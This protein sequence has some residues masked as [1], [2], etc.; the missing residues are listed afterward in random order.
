MDHTEEDLRATSDA[1]AYDADRLAEI[2]KEKASLDVTDS[3]L[4]ELSAEAETLARHLLPKTV[5]ETEL[6]NEAQP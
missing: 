1:I 5:A 4:V 6:A 3:R 2:E